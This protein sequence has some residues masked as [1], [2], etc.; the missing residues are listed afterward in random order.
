M[1]SLKLL[2]TVAMVI[3]TSGCYMRHSQ[4]YYEYAPDM[5][6]SPGLKAQK[7]GAM[8]PPVQGTIP[9]FFRPYSIKTM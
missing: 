4:Q 6:F 3:A 1:R 9:R 5:H 2:F 8:R 7:E